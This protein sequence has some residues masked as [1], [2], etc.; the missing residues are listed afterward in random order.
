MMLKQKLR[1]A[2]DLPELN[3]ALFAFLLNFVWEMLQS[4][5]FHGM[6]EA[7]H[8]DAV[9]VCAQATIGDVGIALAAFWVVAWLGGRGRSWPLRPTAAQVAAFTVFGLLVTMAFELLA[10]QVWDR[11]SYSAAMPVTPLLEVGLLP[12][13]QWT[14]LPPLVIWFVHRQLT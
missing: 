12:L 3:V 10:T 4:G 2:L 5:F 14:A 6:A 8:W 13:L 7:F 11:W 1:A 9:L